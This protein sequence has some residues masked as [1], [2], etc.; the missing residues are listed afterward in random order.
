[1]PKTTT[2]IDGNIAVTVSD[3][4]AEVEDAPSLSPIRRAVMPDGTVEYTN[5]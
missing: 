3:D 1:M 5:L 2:D 4:D